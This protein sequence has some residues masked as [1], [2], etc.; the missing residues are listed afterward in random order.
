VRDH[1]G[2]PRDE[3]R[4]PCVQK[5]GFR[6]RNRRFSKENSTVSRRKRGVVSENSSFSLRLPSLSDPGRDF[7][8]EPFISGSENDRLPLR[9]LG[10]RGEK[11][12]RLSRN[13]VFASENLVSSSSTVVSRPRNFASVSESER[14]S[15]RLSPRSSPERCPAPRRRGRRPVDRRLWP[16]TRDFSRQLVERPPREGDFSVQKPRRGFRTLDFSSNVTPRSAPS[17]SR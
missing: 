5:R 15:L 1:G 7:S 10:P 8:P 4:P 16:R 9:N 2:R 12:G 13:V 11:S 14:F 3:G 6:K 17:R